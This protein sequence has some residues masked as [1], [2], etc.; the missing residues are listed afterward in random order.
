MLRERTIIDRMGVTLKE[1]RQRHRA[2]ESSVA[3][4]AL[5]SNDWRLTGAAH[6]LECTP[7][8]L[9]RVI[10]RDPELRRDYAKNKHGAGRPA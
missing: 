3:R 4:E 8:I 5:L 10:D 1:L 9:L 6:Q 2:E 7:Q